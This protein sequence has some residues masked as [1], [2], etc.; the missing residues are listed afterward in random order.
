MTG[1]IDIGTLA[2]CL[3]LGNFMQLL[4]FFIQYRIDEKRKGP[5][6][7][8]LAS[9]VLTCGFAVNFLRDVPTLHNAP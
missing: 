1:S 3:G 4:A 8:T 7:W 2:I 9:A 5:G 6:C